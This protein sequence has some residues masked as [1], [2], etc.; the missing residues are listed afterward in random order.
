MIEYLLAKEK[1]LYTMKEKK[2]KREKEKVALLRIDKIE[3][4]LTKRI[5]KWDFYL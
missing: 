2:K 1:F 5:L 3:F 4:F